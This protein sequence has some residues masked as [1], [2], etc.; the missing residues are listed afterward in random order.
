MAPKSAA[1]LTLIVLLAA[2]ASA[3]THI[4]YDIKGQS[5]P[6]QWA[7]TSFP[8]RY[9]IDARLSSRAA[10]I[11][12][13]FG[14]WEAIADANVRFERGN[15]VNRGVSANDGR[16]VVSEAE[17]LFANQGAMAM[18]TYTFDE[19]GRFT[20]VDIQ[21]D[22][23]LFGDNFNERMA[24]QHEVGHLLGL[25]HSAVLSSVMFPHVRRGDDEVTFD[26][27][28]RVAIAMTY[29][30]SDPA[31]NGAT[32][33]G[34]IMGDNGGIFAAQVVALTERGA[35]V[36]TALTDPSGAFTIAGLPTGTYRLYVEPLDGPGTISDLR[37]VYRKA[38]VVS[39]PTQFYSEPLRVESGKVYGNLMLSVNGSIKLNPQILGASA[40]G[41]GAFSLGREVVAVKP[42]QTFDLAIAGDG[43]TSGMTQFEILDPSFRRISDFKWAGGYVT[44]T[45]TVA[46]DAPSGSAV[47]LVKSGNESATLTGAL[48]ITR[49]GKSRAV[50]R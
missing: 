27:D 33:Q 6:I 34:R 42:G 4:T 41:A 9:D 20:D 21:V 46:A 24:L 28:D 2:S 15:I 13:A 29:P 11:D 47:V 35:P 18:T 17:S 39:F 32:L 23:K 48:R 22:P 44:A 7:P 3:A 12:A 16:I 36:A 10:D 25:D 1:F 40:Q 37:G 8:L 14:A 19:S 49:P 31:L 50:R 45:Y 30:R 38:E 5:T 43:F 26:S